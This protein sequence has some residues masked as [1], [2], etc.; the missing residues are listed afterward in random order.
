MR[1]HRR[2]RAAENEYLFGH[3]LSMV[4]LRLFGLR[5]RLISRSNHRPHAS[6][7]SRRYRSWSDLAAIDA[8][9]A[10]SIALDS[11][12]AP[13]VSS[14]SAVER[15]AP[16]G[17]ATFFPASGGAEP[18]TGSNSEVLPGWMLPGRGHAEPAL[19]RA[20]DIGDDVAEQVVG[21]DHLILPGILHQE[22]RERIDVLVRG[23]D[24]RIRCRD[25]LEHALPQR[26][27][28]LHRVAL[29]GHADPGQAAR[30]S[31]TRTRA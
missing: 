10:A 30:A 13:S 18:W 11:S 2:A 3:E 1:R 4:E 25:F 5:V 9:T 17:F 23:G 6:R 26:V 21:D 28:L 29:V 7:A 31:Q 16:I 22:H 15:I 20:A 14:I 12:R 19:Q 24:A 27:P 8:S